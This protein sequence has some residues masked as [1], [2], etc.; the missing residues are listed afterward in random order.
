MSTVLLLMVAVPTLAVVAAMLYAGGALLG[1]WDRSTSGPVVVA[2]RIMAAPALPPAPVMT[3]PVAPSVVPAVPAAPVPTAPAHAMPVTPR[4]AKGS[5]PP[6]IPSTRT[7]S[8]RGQT[9]SVIVD[10]ARE[11]ATIPDHLRRN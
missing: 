7:I 9:P 11:E 2:P 4:L 3:A 6:P 8:P 10:F 5:I 1:R